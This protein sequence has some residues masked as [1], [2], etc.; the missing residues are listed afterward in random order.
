M[1]YTSSEGLNKNS[2]RGILIPL[3]KSIWEY[4]LPE[5]SWGTVKLYVLTLLLPVTT[6]SAERSFLH[7]KELRLSS[8]TAQV[9]LSA[10]AML[11]IEDKCLV[12]KKV[13]FTKQK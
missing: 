3:L 5:I 2:N 4:G 6:T 9:R 13:H 8:E 12:Y 1:L 10:L 11:S 7:W